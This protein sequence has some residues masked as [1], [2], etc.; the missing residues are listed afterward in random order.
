[1]LACRTD[2]T[3]VPALPVEFAV[4][5]APGPACTVGCLIE[6]DP[7][8][9]WAPATELTKSPATAAASMWN[10]KVMPRFLTNS[11]ALAV[12]AVAGIYARVVDCSTNPV[13]L[14]TP[15]ALALSVGVI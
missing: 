4:A 8:R 6:A 12:A 5:L 13:A 14:L 1:M 15:R 11:D 10:F 2:G 9:I 7:S 3:A